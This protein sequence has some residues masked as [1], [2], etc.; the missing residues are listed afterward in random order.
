[1]KRCM[2]VCIYIYIYI[3][4]ICRE[5]ERER[6]RESIPISKIGLTCNEVGP[7]GVRY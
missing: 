5:R 2:Y 1:L 4:I 6:E 3:Y 7:I